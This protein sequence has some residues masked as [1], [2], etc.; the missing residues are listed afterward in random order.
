[1]VARVVEKVLLSAVDCLNKNMS[2]HKVDKK[3][4]FSAR[5]LPRLED[6]E[7]VRSLVSSNASIVSLATEKKGILSRFSVV[8]LRWFHGH[9]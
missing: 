8:V 1:M 9:R 5:E 6:A 2:I 4:F 3:F 7:I